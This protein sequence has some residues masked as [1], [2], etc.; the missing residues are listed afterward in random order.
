MGTW[1]RPSLFADSARARAG[2]ARR[3]DRGTGARPPG[4]HAGKAMHLAVGQVGPFGLSALFASMGAT[5]NTLRRLD[6][7]SKSASPR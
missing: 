4:R 3:S 2:G 5:W 7:T 6:L 1:R